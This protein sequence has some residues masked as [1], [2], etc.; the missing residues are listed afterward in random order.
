MPAIR[1]LVVDDH[2]LFRRGLVALLAGDPDLEVAGE[3]GDAA[4]A[5]RKAQALQPDVV[6]LDNHLPGAT[7]LQALAEL[8]AAA[9]AARIVMLTV[10]E[11]EQDLRAALRGGANGYLLKTI[12]GDAL[13]AA[14]QRVMRGEPVVSPEMM[15]KLVAAVQ[16][17]V[18]TA[19]AGAAPEP[20]AQLSPREQE[21][22]RQIAR[23]ASNKEIARTLDIAETTVKIHVQHILRKL[24]VSSRVQAALAAGTPA[25]A[26]GS[27]HQA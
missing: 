27:L 2:N 5:V 25:P 1:L 11:D 21:V 12:E 6:L 18:P 16:A 13:G 15:G 4:E 24:G 20:L 19:R 10:S 23:G 22:L 8:R 17:P 3:A 7:G 26:G 9:P 14:L